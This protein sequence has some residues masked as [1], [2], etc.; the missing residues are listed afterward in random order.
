M[1]QIEG[2]SSAL[3]G[4]LRKGVSKLRSEV[5]HRTELMKY[6]GKLPDLSQADKQLCEELK[7]T[8]IVMTSL[9]DLGISS[10]PQLM[11]ATE[12]M[13]PRLQRT[14]IAGNLSSNMRSAASHCLY[15]DPVAIAQKF[16]AIHL[17]GLQDRILDI[18]EN[19]YGAPMSCIGV[20]MRRDIADGQQ[21]GTK[22]WHIDGE[23]RK[24]MKIAV[25]LNDVDDEGGPFEYI[26]L[27]D[28]PSYKDF[29]SSSIYDED[30]EKVVPR[31]KWVP[32]TGAKGTVI[33][34]DNARLFH[35]GRTPLKDRY[36]I[37]YAYAYRQ[38]RRPEACERS[39]WRTG[40]PYLAD[41]LTQRQKDAI[42]NYAGLPTIPRTLKD[43]ALAEIRS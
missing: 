10:T 12:E 8:G 33:F 19:Y 21:K 17:W 40:I 3:G 32:C 43:K 5:A 14:D 37:F 22:L 41:K 6:F 18:L 11:A 2:L 39:P 38:P 28:S 31:S 36:T 1:A 23:D 7:R 26:P 24:V 42:W 15:G 34:A 35:H 9:E 20:N 29:P 13:I 16:P 30:M 27:E 25:Y 4:K